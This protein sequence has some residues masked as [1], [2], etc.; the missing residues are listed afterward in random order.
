MLVVGLTGGI[1]SGK[2]TVANLFAERGVPV[3]DADIVAREITTPDKPAFAKIVKHFG[4]DVVMPGG[5]LNRSRLRSIIF[6]DKRERLW[7]ENLLHPLIRD[8]MRKQLSALSVPYCIAVIPLLLEVEFYSFINRILVIDAPESAQVDRVLSRDRSSR[9]EIEAILKSQASRHDR[10]AKA[11]D[12]IVNDGVIA[13]LAPQ[14]EKLHAM[15]TQLGREK[16]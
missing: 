15:Y 11:H 1:G 6:A 2:T 14:I 10:R 5:T 13:D 8:E 9:S 12:V 3:I 16:N 4:D 7:L